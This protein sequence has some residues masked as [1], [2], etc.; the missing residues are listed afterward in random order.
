MLIMFLN[1]WIHTSCET[2]PICHLIIILWWLQFLWLSV[3]IL[4]NCYIHS[5]KIY[6]FICFHSLQEVTI[7]LH[8]HCV[9]CVGLN[10][11]EMIKLRLILEHNCKDYIPKFLFLQ[12]LGCCLQ[13]ILSDFWAFT[14]F[15]V[16][17]DFL[18]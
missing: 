12:L 8:N 16:L 11:P 3:Q 9:Y 13:I 17:S 6:G 2:F 15:G 18:W 7:P 14:G 5:K 10:M 1:F 4:N